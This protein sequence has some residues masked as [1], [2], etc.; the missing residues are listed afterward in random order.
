MVRG[1]RDLPYELLRCLVAAGFV[2][3]RHHR[4]SGWSDEGCL[5]YE[6]PVPGFLIRKVYRPGGP[7]LGLSYRHAVDRAGHSRAV[8]LPQYAEALRNARF[9]VDE[10]PIRYGAHCGRLRTVLVILDGWAR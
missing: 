2:E 4:G 6:P 3:G 10:Q 5:E 8:W 9:T 7:G 1:G